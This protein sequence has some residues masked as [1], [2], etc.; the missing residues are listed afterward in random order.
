MPRGGTWATLIAAR[1]LAYFAAV[2]AE[3]F[4]AE[5]TQVFFSRPTMF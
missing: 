2:F 3:M 4:R 1:S 5:P